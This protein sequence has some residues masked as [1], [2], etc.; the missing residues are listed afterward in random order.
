MKAYVTST[1]I[2]GKALAVE[3]DTCE[4]GNA[5]YA[6]VNETDDTESAVNV[7]DI[8]ATPAVIT[9]APEEEQEI[10]V[11][12]F[13]GGMYSNIEIDNEDCEFVSE[14]PA[15][16]TVT[17]GVIKGVAAGKTNVTVT[18]EGHKD[19]IEVTVAGA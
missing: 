6:Y 11:I 5:V 15:T 7:T 4:A 16:A 1:N 19:V 14:T 9:L 8:A 3:G 10:S 12:G 17:N 13:R 2:D 18:Y